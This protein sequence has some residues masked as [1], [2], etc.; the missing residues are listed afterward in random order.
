M[1]SSMASSSS[2][3]VPVSFDSLSDASVATKAKVHGVVT[4]VS[5]MK[6]TSTTQFF[7]AKLVDNDREIRVVGFSP[8]LRKRLADYE[9]KQSL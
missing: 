3:V 5:P 8:I 4:C 9:K 6:K 7:D 1:A 2:D